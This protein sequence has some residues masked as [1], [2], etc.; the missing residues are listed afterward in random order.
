MME[1]KQERGQDNEGAR[2]ESVWK[3]SLR[4]RGSE[5]SRKTQVRG[6]GPRRA[7]LWGS[8]ATGQ[9]LGAS[10]ETNDVLRVGELNLDFKNSGKCGTALS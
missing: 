1:M 5:V 4:R 9:S 10:S 7:R 6:E 3:T 8:C 2:A